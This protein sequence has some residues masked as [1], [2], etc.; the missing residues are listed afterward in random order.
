[1]VYI[2]ILFCLFHVQSENHGIYNYV[3]LYISCTG[4]DHGIYN[5]LILPISCTGEKPYYIY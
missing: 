5:Y 4:V 2:T 3:I 1:M